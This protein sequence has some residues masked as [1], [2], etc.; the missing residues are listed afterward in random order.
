M[1]TKDL[2]VLIIFASYLGTTT[3][4]QQYYSYLHQDVVCED[5][6]EE[7]KEDIRAL[8]RFNSSWSNSSKI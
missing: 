1:Y 7:T 2:L 4:M 6:L 8:C 5:Y 3:L